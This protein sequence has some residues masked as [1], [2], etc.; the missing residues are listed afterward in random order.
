MA[1]EHPTR[2]LALMRY[3]LVL[4]DS[5]GRTEVGSFDALEP[6]RE[7]FEALCQDRWCNDDGT[8]RGVSLLERSPEGERVV[9]NHQFQ[10]DG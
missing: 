3:S 1:P 5:W 9:A 10:A 4:Q 8:V 2:A 7:A 6:A